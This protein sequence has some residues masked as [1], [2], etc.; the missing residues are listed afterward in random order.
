M[1]SYTE[2]DCFNGCSVFTVSL[3]WGF[4]TSFPV[5]RTGFVRS[6][7]VVITN[8]QLPS[9]NRSPYVSKTAQN[10]YRYEF[11]RHAPRRWP[12][13]P[14]KK[15]NR[16]VSKARRTS[17]YYYYYYYYMFMLP[18]TCFV[19]IVTSVNKL[20]INLPCD[21]CYCTGTKVKRYARV[22]CNVK[23][24]EIMLLCR[25]SLCLY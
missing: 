22:C 4:C 11:S 17:A 24:A 8:G 7:P 1:A 9:I 23:R 2:L 18:Y 25:T 13:A 6:I 20:F 21:Y 12:P 15:K 3:Q 10:K 5:Y 16:D 14:K 19:R